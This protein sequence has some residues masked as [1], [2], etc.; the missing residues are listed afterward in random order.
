MVSILAWIVLWAV[1]ITLAVSALFLALPVRITICA[2]SAP[3]RRF[4]VHVGLLGGIV[5]VISVVD[6]DR[7]GMSDAKKQKKAESRARR[8]AR[9]KQ[10]GRA[11]GR[12]MK[13]SVQV[14]L[15]GI[16]ALLGDLLAE[17]HFE[18]LEVQAIF[19]LEDPGDTGT[20]FGL[21]TP[22]MYGLPP[23][24]RISLQAQPDFGQVRL[25]GRVDAAIRFIPARL[26][27]PFMS[28]VWTAF[29]DVRS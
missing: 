6:S 3:S 14:W 24:G 15:R 12:I 4:V 19:G 23:H 27:L 11:G 29:R 16:P 26:V 17:I 1:L 5:P 20:V 18:Q 22:W 10:G 28:Y 2:R 21:L 13:P 8:K 9:K 7:P 25:D